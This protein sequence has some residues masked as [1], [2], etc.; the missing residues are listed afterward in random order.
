MAF[1][2]KDVAELRAKT[3]VGMM[4]CK[5]ALTE[6]NGNFDEAIKVL[7][8]IGL[9]AADKKQARIAAEGAVFSYIH[10]NGSIGVLLEINCETDFVAKAPDFQEAGRNIAMQI[11]AFKPKYVSSADVDKAELEEEKQILTVQARNEGKPEKIIEKMVEGRI[12]KYYEEVCLLDQAY[13][14]DNSITVA[15]YVQELTLKFGEKISIRRF[16]IFVMGEGL[17]K[18][19]DNLAEEIA[20]MSGGNK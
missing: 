11:E 10:M 16:T 5:K 19:Q 4:E 8:E 12:K 18:R 9:K 13:V 7:R 20:K 6:T 15:Q 14:K 3:G 1:T 2:A 17:E